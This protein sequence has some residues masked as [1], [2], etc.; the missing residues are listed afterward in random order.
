MRIST[1][2][3]L[4]AAMGLLAACG[5]VSAQSMF[6]SGST[7]NQFG[8]RPQGDFNTGNFG[9]SQSGS[10]F[11]LGTTGFPGQSGVRA[12]APA[13]GESI[14]SAN[15]FQ[16][17]TAQARNFVGAGQD[18]QA[19]V[20]AATTGQ[21]F[22]SDLVGPGSRRNTADVNRVGGGFGAAGR[23][24]TEL[25][26]RIR[27]GFQRPQPTTEAVRRSLADR[28]IRLGQIQTRSPLD[29]S[30]QGATA[31]LR[32][33]VA[34]DRDRILAEQMVRL[35]PGVWKVQNELVVASVPAPASVPVPDDPGGN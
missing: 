22:R 10:S 2:L 24:Q 18:P 3:A 20:G 14:F 31:T 12:S 6:S 32:G 27:L 28:V 8:A 23:G 15:E 35:E 7:G 26:A 29:V 1:T 33:S 25:R 13:L 34:T 19:F 30:V 4:A 16:M 11:G 5:D 9:L 17:G 21:G